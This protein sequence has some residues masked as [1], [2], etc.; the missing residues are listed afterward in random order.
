MKT[1]KVKI[2]CPECKTILDVDELLVSQFE[3]SIRKDL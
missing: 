1:Q 3:D 2:N